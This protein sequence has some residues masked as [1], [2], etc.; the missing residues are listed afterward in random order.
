MYF[1]IL[2]IFVCFFF[3]FHTLKYIYIFPSRSYSYN[4]ISIWK[5]GLNRY[6]ICSMSLSIL[7]NNCTISFSFICIHYIGSRPVKCHPYCLFRVTPWPYNIRL[8]WNVNALWS[9]TISSSWLKKNRWSHH[10]NVLLLTTCV[11]LF[12]KIW[13]FLT[14]CV[15]YLS[16]RLGSFGSLTPVPNQRYLMLPWVIVPSTKPISK[17]KSSF[18]QDFTAYALLLFPISVLLTPD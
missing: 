5:W 13:H 12:R 11:F 18:L 3:F 17:K 16:T 14:R 15:S 2:S 4:S 9:V 8:S 10:L 7:L 1:S 6:C